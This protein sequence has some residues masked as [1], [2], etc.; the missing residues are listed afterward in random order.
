ML[1]GQLWPSLSFLLQ[2]WG[3]SDHPRKMRPWHDAS[4]SRYRMGGEQEVNEF[5]RTLPLRS[6]SRGHET[7]VIVFFRSSLSL[8]LRGG[9]T[10]YFFVLVAR[11]LLISGFRP[12]A[13]QLSASA[14]S[15]GDRP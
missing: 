8:R 1:S 11:I 5:R 15:V 7:S 4:L 6:R 14:N 10:G 12:T 2:Q 13:N 3:G 9:P